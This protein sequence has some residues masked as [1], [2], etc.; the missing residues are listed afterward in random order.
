MRVDKFLNAVNIVKRRA[1]AQDMLANGVVKIAGVKLKASRDVKVGD[2]IEIAF[3]E[4]SKFYQVLQIPEQKTIKK[5][6]SHL[7]YKEVQQ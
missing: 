7:Y 1:I 3:L 5:N 2:I 6:D 4:K